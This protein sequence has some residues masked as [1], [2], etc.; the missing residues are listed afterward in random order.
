MINDLNAVTVFLKVVELGSFRAAA[1]ALRL[2]RSTVSLRVAQL[3]DQLGV[4]LL[5]R[6]TRALRLTEAG[7]T[8]QAEVTPALET[9]ERAGRLVADRETQPGGS[10]GLTAPI[11]LGQAV[12]G[13]VLA[14]YLRRC[15]ASGWM[16]S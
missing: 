4:R 5:E 11:E 12:L 10:L 15:R 16:S 8:Y 3:E 13:G 9:V 14:E 7:R 6:T 1:Q 2:P